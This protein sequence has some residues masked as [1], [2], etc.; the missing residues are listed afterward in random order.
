MNLN[1]KQLTLITNYLNNLLDYFAFLLIQ[2]SIFSSF[3]S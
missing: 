2:T 1:L 3:Q